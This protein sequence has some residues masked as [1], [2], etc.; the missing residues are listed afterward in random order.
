MW[1][2]TLTSTHKASS[3]LCL[4]PL[5]NSLQPTTTWP[6]FS[7]SRLP[8]RVL[9]QKLRSNLQNLNHWSRLLRLSRLLETPSKSTRIIRLLLQSKPA[10]KKPSISNKMSAWMQDIMEVEDFGPITAKFGRTRLGVPI[11]SISGKEIFTIFPLSLSISRHGIRLK[12][13]NRIMLGK[14]ANSGTEDISEVTATLWTVNATTRCGVPSITKTDGTSR[15]GITRP[16]IQDM[17]LKLR[18]QCHKSG[19][20][21]SQ[22]TTR[23]KTRLQ[24]KG[25]SNSYLLPS[26]PPRP[27]SSMKTWTSS[28]RRSFDCTSNVAVLNSAIRKNKLLGRSRLM[29]AKKLRSQWWLFLKTKEKA[30]SES[31]LLKNGSELRRRIPSPT[32]KVESH[33]LRSRNLRSSLWIDFLR[34]TQDRAKKKRPNWRTSWDWPCVM[35]FC[36]LRGKESGSRMETGNER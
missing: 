28:P 12:V 22:R 16:M 24:L 2:L 15:I 36:G 5:T 35:W 1:N 27:K 11:T 26:L 8:W 6:L 29:L 13:V 30:C 20:R 31:R 14:E 17:F 18:R 19:T 32:A 25:P 34:A 33:E 3:S 7:E 9:L 21:S 23:A 10:S 4:Q